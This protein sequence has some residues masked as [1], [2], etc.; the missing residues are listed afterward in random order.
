MADSVLGTPNRTLS[1]RSLTARLR[2]IKDFPPPQ[3]AAYPIER[4]SCF[5]PR[6]KLRPSENQNSTD[7]VSFLSTIIEKTVLVIQNCKVLLK[8][9]IPILIPSSSPDARETK[10]P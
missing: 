3:L 9:T 7:I 6:F 5:V 4:R 1:P 2:P 10:T 8:F